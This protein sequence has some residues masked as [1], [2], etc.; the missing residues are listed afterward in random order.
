MSRAEPMISLSDTSDER[1]EH[2]VDLV[3]RL[4]SVNEWLFERDA[5][6]EISITIQG[7]WAEYNLAFTWLEEIESLHLACAFDLKVPEPRKTELTRLI[8]LINEQLWLGHFDLWN[9][10]DV[11]MFRHALPLNGGMEPSSRQCEALLNA[12]TENCERYFQAFQYVVWAGL[13]ADA[14]MQS[15]LFETVGEA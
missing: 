10:E 11:V 13:T 15:I 4:A 7:K 1:V 6:D 2:P 14:A 9:K 3:E 12:A 8:A 5:D